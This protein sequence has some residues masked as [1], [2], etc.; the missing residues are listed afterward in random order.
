[1]KKWLYLIGLILFFAV[2]SDAAN[3]NIFGL[4]VIEANK[5]GGELIALARKEFDAFGAE[6]LKKNPFTGK[7]MFNAESGGYVVAHT[8]HNNIY[9]HEFS[10]AEA[11]AKDGNKV[12]LL[13]EKAATG[14]TTP[15]AEIVGMG[16]FDF[17]NIEATNPG[18]IETNVQC[19]VLDAKRQADNIAFNL[20]DN[21]VATPEIINKAVN[22]AIETAR[23]AGLKNIADKVGIVYKD[24]STKIIDLNKFNIENGVKF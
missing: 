24:G 22:N 15:D 16:N 6:W 17:K 9:P 12:K 11:F 8:Q 23:N 3:S 10:M 20:A 4:R 14:I 2:N 1:M 21:T 7:E 13:N 19:Y 5:A 18:K